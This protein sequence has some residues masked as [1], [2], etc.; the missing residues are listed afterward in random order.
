[1]RTDPRIA[2][3][4]IEDRYCSS[5]EWVGT[6]TLY[7]DMDLRTSLW[8]CPECGRDNET[9]HYAEGALA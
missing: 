8:T 7:I 6:T 4:D 1:M 5:C 2:A 3:T 9:H